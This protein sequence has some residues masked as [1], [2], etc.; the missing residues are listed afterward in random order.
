MNK[1][2]SAE[3]ENANSAFCCKLPMCC[4]TIMKCEGRE[5]SYRTLVS[6]DCFFR[7]N[8][9]LIFCWDIMEIETV[10]LKL[11]L[12]FILYFQSFWRKWLF[13][14]HFKNVSAYDRKKQVCDNILSTD[15]TL[16]SC[17]CGETVELSSTDAA[18]H[19]LENVSA[20]SHRVNYG[21]V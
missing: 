1:K 16:T 9:S 7:W 6:C 15:F 20:V 17:V 11:S 5:E 2:I 21:I 14:G 3:V 13:F 18:P 4:D 10:L 19:L 12:L 8:I